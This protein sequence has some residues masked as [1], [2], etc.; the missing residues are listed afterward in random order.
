[1]ITKHKVSL[2]YKIILLSLIFVMLSS[3]A[4]VLFEYCKFQDNY[5][6]IFEGFGKRKSDE[7]KIEL[8]NPL[9]DNNLKKI[10]NILTATVIGSPFIAAVCIKTQ[11]GDIL[12]N[13]D[14][15]KTLLSVKDKKVIK[16]K[17]TRLYLT[18][19]NLDSGSSILVGVSLKS[20][21]LFFLDFLKKIILLFLFGGFV[22]ILISVILFNTYIKPIKTLRKAIELINTGNYQQLKISKLLQKDEIG[23]LFNSFNSMSYSLRKHE[24]ELKKQQNTIF[25]LMKKLIN[26]Q[27][28]ERKKNSPR[29]T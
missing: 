3:V 15:Y 14:E 26:I 27:E 1:M 18:K 22:L 21:D 23:L 25:N 11:T 9:K 28:E 13:K 24:E 10:Q 6:K 2:F 20:A 8:S 19:N 4:L 29:T 7:L 17:N 16:I 12:C 5:Y